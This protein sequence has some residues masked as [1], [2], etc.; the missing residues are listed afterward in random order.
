MITTAERSTNS[1]NIQRH[2]PPQVKH[3]VYDLSVKRAFPKVGRSSVSMTAMPQP[4]IATPARG[5]LSTSV[6]VS[7]ETEPLSVIWDQDSI[8]EVLGWIRQ[9][10]DLSPMLAPVPGVS[11]TELRWLARIGALVLSHLGRDAPVALVNSLSTPMTIT[12]PSD[13]AVA[14]SR[15]V[16]HNPYSHLSELYSQVVSPV[17]RRSLG[18]FFTPRDAT[19]SIVESYSNRF[20][21]PETLVDVGAGVGIF[22]EVACA[23]WP[24]T[25]AYA[26][27][28]NP[29]TL[30]LQAVASRAR[31]LGRVTLELADYRDWLMKVDLN[32]PTLFLGNPPYTR[33]QLLRK[34]ERSLLID[35]ACR[36]VGQRANLSTLFLAMT[37]CRLGKRDSLAMII[38]AGWMQADY[39][40]NLRAWLRQADHRPIMFRRADS[41][42]FPQAIVD[43]VVVE[44][45]PEFAREQPIRLSNWASTEVCKLDRNG[46]K[47]PFLRSSGVLGV[48]PSNASLGP[49]LGDVLRVSRGIATGSNPVFVQPR[50]QWDLAGVDQ[51]YT[52]TVVRRLRPGVSAAQPVQE[53][54]E[55]LTLS[56]YTRG[57][58]PGVDNWLTNAEAHGADQA[59]LCQKRAAWYD[60]SSELRTPDVIL[61]SLARGVFHVATNDGGFVITNNLFGGYW[62]HCTDQDIRQRILEWLRSDEGQKALGA[63]ASMEGN[64]L[65]RLSPRAVAELRLPPR[66]LSRATVG[67]LSSGNALG[68]GGAS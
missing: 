31:S 55:L 9:V 4:W 18:T 37:L 34:P 68:S 43:T 52:L 24:L 41:W 17:H 23:R 49:R 64:G 63:S 46:G 13:I 26:V 45:G 27:D 22:T 38:P 66:L 57:S 1:G 30:G 16:A 15:L 7:C 50:A 33:W 19:M 11:A 61:T 5:G 67:S 58:A 12:P 3:H 59:Y 36:L 14:F 10:D 51:S 29:V 32:G 54:A 28:I 62:V 25:Q 35:A 42:R 44:V 2:V 20:G 8:Q 6:P 53:T 39:G 21:A 40:K 65:R 60:L 56:G 47:A 48:L